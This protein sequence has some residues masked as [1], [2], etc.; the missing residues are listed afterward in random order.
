MLRQ[1]QM[2][3]NL[4]VQLLK[5][6]MGFNS[7]RFSALPVGGP[8]HFDTKTL[9]FKEA[10]GHSLVGGPRRWIGGASSSLDDMNPMQEK[11][12]DK[13]M[14]ATGEERPRRPLYNPLSR[15]HSVSQSRVQYIYDKHRELA[16]EVEL[17]KPKGKQFVTRHSLH[18]GRQDKI[19]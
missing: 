6:T 10:T 1:I 8:K 3:A 16:H 15:R 13:E 17:R 4:Q 5:S 19:N 9:S 11:K 7:R 14:E 12:A 2:R 18:S